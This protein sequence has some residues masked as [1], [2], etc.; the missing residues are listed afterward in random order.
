MYTQS[1]FS[2]SKK[3]EKNM[4]NFHLKIIIFTA[5]KK[6]CMLHERV[7]VMQRMLCG[8]QT[9]CCCCFFVFVFES[10]S[11]DQSLRK[12]TKTLWMAL[13]CKTITFGDV[14]D[15]LLTV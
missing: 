5:V 12:N 2:V 10:L 11:I 8:N 7:F 14:I 6:C 15:V 3:K 9:L 1:I 13:K 4:K